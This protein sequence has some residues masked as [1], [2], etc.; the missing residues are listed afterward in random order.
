MRA[1]TESAGPTVLFGDGRVLRMG[2]N[3]SFH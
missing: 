1:H 2:R 3:A